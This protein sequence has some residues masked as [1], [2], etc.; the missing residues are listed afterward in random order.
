VWVASGI[1]S[2]RNECFCHDYHSNRQNDE[3][4]FDLTHDQRIYKNAN[5]GITEL[6]NKSEGPKSEEDEAVLVDQLN[7]KDNSSRLAGNWR[8]NNS[9][10]AQLYQVLKR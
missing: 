5:V 4:E 2:F 7:K 9:N 3:D 10:E 6:C 8:R 1:T